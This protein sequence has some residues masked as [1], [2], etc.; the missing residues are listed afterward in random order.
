M[1][2][3]EK[4]TTRPEELEP[5]CAEPEDS[6][7]GLPITTLEELKSEPRAPW[8]VQDLIRQRS[9]VLMHGKTGHYKTFLALD[10]LASLV[11]G[12]DWLGHAVKR[13]DQSSTWPRR[14]PRPSL[15]A[16]MLGAPE[17]ASASRLTGSR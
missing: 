17:P 8:L 7:F 16:S 10:L 3:L 6:S 5:D 11:L 1:S 9:T 13:P 4:A 14:G 12:R 15:N 2:V